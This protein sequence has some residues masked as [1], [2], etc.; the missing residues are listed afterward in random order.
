MASFS[1][2][3]R[4]FGGKVVTTSLDSKK[5]TQVLALRRLPE[6]GGI[7]TDIRG[8]DRLDIMAEQR[9]EDSTQFWHIADANTDLDATELTKTVGRKI[10]VPDQP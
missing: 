9:Y 1:R 2:S 10:E 4:Y 6:V 8:G 5:Q 3:S 7:P